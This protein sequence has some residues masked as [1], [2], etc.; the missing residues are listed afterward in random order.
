MALPPKIVAVN[1]DKFIP[2]PQ[3]FKQSDLLTL[4]G[5]GVEE[6]EIEMRDEV[7]DQIEWGASETVSATIGQ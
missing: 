2:F 6:V 4:A 7:S 1:P 3:T 5:D